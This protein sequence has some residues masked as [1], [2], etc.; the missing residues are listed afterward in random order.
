MDRP[1]YSRATRE[2][3]VAPGL[4]ARRLDVMDARQLDPNQADY[5]LVDSARSARADYGVRVLSRL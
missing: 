2:K 5:M 3:S 4:A 1:S